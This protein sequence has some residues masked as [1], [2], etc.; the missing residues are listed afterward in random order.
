MYT[1][2]CLLINEAKDPK[3]KKKV[4]F[5]RCVLHVGALHVYFE[6]RKRNINCHHFVL[7]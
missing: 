6:L 7:V 2:V 4:P 1:L 5:P 3:I